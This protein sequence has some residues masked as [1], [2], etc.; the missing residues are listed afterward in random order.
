[1]EFRDYYKT[2]G[3]E[4]SASGAEIKAAFRKL[5]RKHHPDVNPNNKDAEKK[6]KEINEAYQVIGDAEKRKKYDELGADWEHGVSQDEMRRRYARQQQAAGGG[7]GGFE[8]GGD[9]SD[10]FSQ[11]F[12]GSGG[13]RFHR[14]AARGFSGFDFGNEQPARGPDLRAEVAITLGEAIH[15]AK[16]RLDLSA[17]DRCATCGGSG[18]VAH[19][20][21][22]GK[23]RVI[24]SA[25]E[26]PT[27]GGE[28]MIPARRT[29]EVSI[30]AGAADGSQLR[31]KGQGGHGSRKDLNGDLFMTIRIEPHPVFTLSERD[32]RC[33]LPVWD[34]EAA[35]GAEVT[36]PT[37]DGKIALKIPAGSQTGRVM[38]LR[39]RGLPA[40]GKDSAGDLLF[41]LKVL[42]PTDLTDDERALMEKLAESR[43]ERGV[44]DPRA[45][46][47]RS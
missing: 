2:L 15:G 35:L 33:Q 37:I 3:V 1:M 40:R 13:G 5:A 44:T 10:F 30:S 25:E 24:R 29:L 43:R 18:M 46:L 42:A 39:G 7:A 16:R 31:L 21:K 36:A 32:L 19:E 12:G 41:E 4:R 34:Y 17:E 22:Q 38:R 23:A 20:E 9:F 45:E 6:F 27:C 11:Y 26:C 8:T 47:M 14:G 28:G